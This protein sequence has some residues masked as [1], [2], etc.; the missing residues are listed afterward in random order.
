MTP[1]DW[2]SCLIEVVNH[3]PTA[4][5]DKYGPADAKWVTR[6]VGNP[7]IKLAAMKIGRRWFT[8]KAAIDR[9]MDGYRE[10]IDYMYSDNPQ[11]L[12]DYAAFVQVSEPTAK[13]VRD[14]FFP[15]SLVDPDA[16]KGL[17][18]VMKEAVNL[19]FI[20]EPLTQ[21]QLDELIQIPPRKK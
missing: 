1:T 7:P 21:K 4:V 18:S 14:E 2:T 10:T 12:K 19:K 6:G 13:R 5:R 11:V 8:S 20:S 3:L 15:K 17:D 16:I 9:F